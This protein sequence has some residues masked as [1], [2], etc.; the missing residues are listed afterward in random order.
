MKKFLKTL[1]GRKNK[2]KAPPSG[3]AGIPTHLIQELVDKVEEIIPLSISAVETSLGN[4]D[5]S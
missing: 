5:F 3:E 4:K 2:P 1:L